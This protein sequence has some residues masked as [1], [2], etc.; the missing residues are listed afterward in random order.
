[1]SRAAFLGRRALYARPL[2][3]RVFRNRRLRFGW[4]RGSHRLFH[5]AL[6]PGVRLRTLRAC[7]GLSFNAARRVKPGDCEAAVQ[8]CAPSQPDTCTCASVLQP[9]AFALVLQ[10]CPEGFRFV[11]RFS[12]RRSTGKFTLSGLKPAASLILFGRSACQSA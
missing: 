3:A 12:L 4:T 9:R 6:V 11:M 1:M 10:P 7:R 8:S 2:E 5:F